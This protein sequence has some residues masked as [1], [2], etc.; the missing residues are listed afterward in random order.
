MLLAEVHGHHIQ[1][2][3]NSE[4][5]L[6]SAV[7]GHI[8]Y[9]PPSQFWPELFKYALAMPDAVNRTLSD[10]LSDIGIEIGKFE[11]L[12]IHFWPSHPQFGTPDLILVFYGTNLHPLV[13]L[14]EAKLWAHKSGTGD[15]DQIARYLRL[16]DDA[17]HVRPRLPAVFTSA[18]IYLTEHDSL[19]ELEESIGVYENPVKA[20]TQVFRLQWQDILLAVSYALPSATGPAKLILRDVASFLSRRGLEYFFGFRRVLLPAINPQRVKIFDQGL[21]MRMTLSF[22]FKTKRLMDGSPF[23]TEIHL[24]SSFT[25]RRGAWL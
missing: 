25:I 6:T 12:E 16:L 17:D 2:A 18:L 20:V 24:P 4:D 23:F 3:Q 14:I 9:L 22:P 7:F 21:F 15:F 10:H 8:R 11:A 19:A 5:Y 1:E 13:I